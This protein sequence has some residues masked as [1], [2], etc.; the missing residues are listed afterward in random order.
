MIASDSEPADT[1]RNVIE[2]EPAAM[3]STQQLYVAG[4]A[5]PPDTV[6]IKVSLALMNEL[7]SVK[8]TLVVAANAALF[9]VIRPADLFKVTPVDLLVNC[10]T[11]P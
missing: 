4:L 10:V 1:L 9:I 7:V 11:A 5:L 3:L 8:E 2:H 6:T